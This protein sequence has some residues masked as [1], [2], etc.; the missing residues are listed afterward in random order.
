MP[1][2]WKGFPLGNPGTA[3]SPG[4]RCRRPF[5]GPSPWISGANPVLPPGVVW[6]FVFECMQPLERQEKGK[7]DSDANQSNRPAQ[8]HL[9]RS[10]LVQIDSR[11]P[12]G[13][14]RHSDEES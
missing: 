13:E 12:Y 1:S 11:P 5:L 3:I 4:K 6:G 14:R 10:V 2:A 9:G 7:H 8:N